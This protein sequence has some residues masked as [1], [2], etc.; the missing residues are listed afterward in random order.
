M[1]RAKQYRKLFDLAVKAQQCESRDDARKLI[2]KAE[3]T[4][5]KLAKSLVSC[6]Q[7]LSD[8]RY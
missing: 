6:L 2:R 8:D 1:K 3:K 4:E 5:K 7:V